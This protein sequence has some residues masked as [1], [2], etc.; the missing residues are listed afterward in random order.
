MAPHVTAPTVSG[1]G[2]GAHGAPHCEN[3]DPTSSIA[4]KL[5]RFPETEISV[6][7]VGSGIGGLT[8]ALECWRKGHSVRIWERSAGPVYSGELCRKTTM[9]SQ[10]L[11]FFAPLILEC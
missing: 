4:S 10:G 11:T 1:N 3:G 8:S 9:S 6:L 5:K 2:L 7:I